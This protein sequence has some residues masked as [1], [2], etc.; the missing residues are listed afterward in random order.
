MVAQND[1]GFRVVCTC[2]RYP[3]GSGRLR[4]E[5]KKRGQNLS[6]GVRKNFALILFQVIIKSFLQIFRDR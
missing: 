6:S 2:A 1:C 4:L 3:I 5:S